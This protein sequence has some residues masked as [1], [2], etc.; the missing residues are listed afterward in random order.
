MFVKGVNEM[1][2]EKRI[3]GLIRGLNEMI[4]DPECTPRMRQ[5]LK[6]ARQI[7][8]DRIAVKPLNEGEE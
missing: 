2:D 4:N 5:H 7:A 6:N 8:R 3:Q 1:T